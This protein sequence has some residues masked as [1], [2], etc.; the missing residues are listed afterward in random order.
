MARPRNMQI[1]LEKQTRKTSL[2]EPQGVGPAGGLWET[3][4]GL[5][6]V[7]LLLH[8][9]G[10]LPPRHLG[11]LSEQ[12]NRQLLITEHSPGTL[13]GP[14]APAPHTLC[15]G[16]CAGCWVSLAVEG[17]PGSPPSLYPGAQPLPCYRV[18]A[19]KMLVTRTGF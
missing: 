10:P 3:G 5:R 9:S 16:G 8:P 7:W 6:R 4:I 2:L 12:R 11:R 13:H 1:A 14:P 19:Q 17:R 18:S 15:G